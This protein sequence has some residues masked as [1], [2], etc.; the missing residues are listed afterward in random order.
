MKPRLLLLVP[1][2]T[3]RAE[4]FVRAARRLAV[5][6]SLASE[7]AS[8]LAQEHPGD[9]PPFDFADP[10]DTADK[11]RHFARKTPVHAVVPVDDRSVLAAATIAEALGLP[12]HPV[13]AARATIN[14]FL[15][16]ERMHAAGIPIPKYTLLSLHASTG[17]LEREL[18]RAVGYPAVL[19]P[20][21]MA[22]SRGV[23]R[24]DNA[25]AFAPAFER[26]ARLVRSEPSPHDALA[27]GHVLAESY[28]DGWEVAVEGMV[29]DGRV[30]VVAIF[31]KPD[32]LEGPVFPETMYVTPS[33]L[34]PDTQAQ[35][36]EITEAAVRAIGLVSGPVHV[37]LRGKDGLVI[38][39]EVHARSIGGLCSRVVRF[40]DGRSLEDVILQHALG[41]VTQIPPRES[42][43][44][45]VWM[46]Q[47]PR[48]G[49]FH[50]LRGAS[51]A[52]E[53]AGVEEVVVTARPGQ[54]LTPLPDGFL[55][56]A[57]IFARAETP[58]QVESSLRAAFARL[59]PVMED[60]SAEAQA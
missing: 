15:A 10:I 45:G 44:A 41:L 35:I 12:H 49:R 48:A 29:T 38:P 20:L 26:L 18:A 33:R 22:A 36:V 16:R 11:A 59:E 53:I 58:E 8:S 23:V 27:R 57:F 3:Y 17:A 31:D 34:P 39:I 51:T 60:L 21:A 7:T 6:L 9:F 46:M 30:D 37:E 42:G 50:S 40:V 1:T 13:D 25:A 5:D 28:V 14:K 52:C 32:P 47:A 43:A 54:Y 2:S 4:A 19:K 24:V 55:Y 56:V